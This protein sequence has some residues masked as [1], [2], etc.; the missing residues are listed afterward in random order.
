[1]AGG[2][3]W[4]TLRECPSVIPTKSIRHLGCEQPLTKPNVDHC[5]TTGKVRG[6]LCT[7]CNTLVL[8]VLENYAGLIPKALSYL[9]ANGKS[10][11]L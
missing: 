6:V 2:V 10:I 11:S 1:M 8:G 7:I 9:A 4:V 3:L 5:H